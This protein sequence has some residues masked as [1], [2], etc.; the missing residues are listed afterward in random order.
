MS[1]LPKPTINLNWLEITYVV[2]ILKNRISWYD[3]ASWVQI[4]V[5]EELIEKMEDIQHANR[6]RLTIPWER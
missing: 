3:N 4:Q 1:D 6:T 2:T 5:V